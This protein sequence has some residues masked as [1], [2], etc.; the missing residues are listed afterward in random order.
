MVRR[1]LLRTEPMLRSVYHVMME[2]SPPNLAGDR[3]IEYSF[4]AANVPEGPGSALDFGCGPRSWLALLASRKGFEATAVDLEPVSW[5]YECPNLEFLRGNL[6]DLDL[7]RDHFDL[8]IN[9]SAIEH[10]GLVG[11]YG[12]ACERIDGDFEVMR[13]LR[14]L[15]RPNKPMLLTIPVGPDRV[16]R[17]LHRVYG[18]ERLPRL[19]NGWEIKKQE[20]W[21]KDRSNRWISTDESRALAHETAPRSY[22]LGLFVLWPGDMRGN[23]TA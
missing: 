9:C 14:A 3:D 1:L 11:R 8:I 15:L 20:F 4:V 12:T 13:F 19:L 21:V 22:S 10:V 5:L 2:G 18:A 6:L 16:F 7:P 17:N 23:A